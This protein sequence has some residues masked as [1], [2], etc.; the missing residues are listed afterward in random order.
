MVAPLYDTVLPPEKA[1]KAF[2]LMKKYLWLC[3][4][5]TGGK[6]LAIRAVEKFM[7]TPRKVSAFIRPREE[8]MDEDWFNLKKSSYPKYLNED[9][10]DNKTV[11]EM[12]FSAEQTAIELINDIYNLI[13]NGG[14]LNK[15]YYNINYSG[16]RLKH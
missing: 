5:M 2:S 13:K 12:L 14:E 4:D 1:E 9:I 10:I 11:E 6:F 3:D 15:D 16:E 8:R 7:E